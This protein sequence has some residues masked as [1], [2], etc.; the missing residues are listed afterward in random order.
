[1]GAHGMASR[2]SGALIRQIAKVGDKL[3]PLP[4]HRGTAGPWQGI[5]ELAPASARLCDYSRQFRSASSFAGSWHQDCHVAAELASRR[6]RRSVS[7]TGCAVRIPR[8]LLA[9]TTGCRYG[10][11]DL[12]RWLTF[13][14]GRARCRSVKGAASHNSITDVGSLLRLANHRHDLL[15]RS[16]VAL[17]LNDRGA[18]VVL[19][20]R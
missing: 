20:S 2:P 3:L 19:P 14:K 17:F 7:G 4:V 12:A 15:V 10:V 6:L 13:T 16:N 11:S 18:R 9:L 1:M 5:G 8:L